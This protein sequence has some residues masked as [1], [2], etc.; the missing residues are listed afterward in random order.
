MT[1]NAEDESIVLGHAVA[2]VDVSC[3]A[4][5][6]GIETAVEAAAKLL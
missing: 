3:P 4:Y 2:G 1:V 5:L 6:Q